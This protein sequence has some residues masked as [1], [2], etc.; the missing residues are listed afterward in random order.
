MTD[1]SHTVSLNFGRNV[2]L[3]TLV[4]VGMERTVLFAVLTPSGR[5]IGL[6]EIRVASILSAASITVFLCTPIWGRISDRW[7]RKRSCQLARLTIR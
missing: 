6:T 4:T 3:A 2:L 1:Q 7:G 5:V